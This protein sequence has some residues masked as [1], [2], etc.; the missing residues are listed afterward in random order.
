MNLEL[1]AR[2][3]EVNLDIVDING[4]K[5]NLHLVEVGNHP[6]FKVLIPIFADVSVGDCITTTD[7]I[8]TRLGNEKP[9]DLCIRIDKFEFVV[10]KSFEVS[11]YLNARVTG[12]F[13]NSDKC[14]LRT[15]GPDK[16]PFYMATLKV[17]DSYGEPFE[18][19]IVGFGNIAKKLSTI[20]KR[21]VIECEVTVKRRQE[22]PGYEFAVLAI[23]VKSE[24]NE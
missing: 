5:Y 17:K 15:L 1:K 9:A 7:W 20:K 4:F 19:I 23:E 2:I 14:F 11:K 22:H 21:S 3:C 6:E 24:V 18:N 16:K 12:M 13:L 10:N 8:L